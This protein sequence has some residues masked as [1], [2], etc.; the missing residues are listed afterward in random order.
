MTKNQCINCGWIS[1]RYVCRY[2]LIATMEPMNQRLLEQPQLIGLSTNEIDEIRKDFPFPKRKDKK[3]T[4]RFVPKDENVK[5]EVT[6]VWLE[7]TPYG[8]YV[9]TKLKGFTFNKTLLSI[10]QN[11]ISLP[12]G[13]NGTGIETDNLGRVKI[14]T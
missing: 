9:K 12:R 10:R 7:F 5:D 1:E 3:M 2:C 11:G 6:E 14:I 8:V 4:H 13:A